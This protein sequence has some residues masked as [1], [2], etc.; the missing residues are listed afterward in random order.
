MDANVVNNELY[1][2]YSSKLE[3]NKPFQSCSPVLMHCNQKYA[4]SRYKILFVG[5]QG[6]SW[7]KD[8]PFTSVE[9]C[10]AEYDKFN[11]G[12]N[13]GNYE[14]NKSPFVRI[15]KFINS[16]VTGRKYDNCV[17][18]TNL[19]KFGWTN[20]MDLK[21]MMWEKQYFNVL[22]EE[23]SIVK[24]DVVVFITG[25]QSNTDITYIKDALGEDIFFIPFERFNDVSMIVD[26]NK[27][28]CTLGKTMYHAP[29]PILKRSQYIGNIEAV[30]I[31][32]ILD[33]FGFT[34]KKHDVKLE[35]AREYAY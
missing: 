7:M 9:D 19:F 13:T 23:I 6:Y 29:M 22:K 15:M 34:H 11:F 25:R 12:D 32:S 2:L 31:D 26:I 8:V 35:S 1:Q 17:L 30:L 21:S 20:K 5:F 24:P 27:S 4:D 33:H 28:G 18:W 10:F 16:H 14:L 3:E